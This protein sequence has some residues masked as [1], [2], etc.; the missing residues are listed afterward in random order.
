MTAARKPRPKAK[1]KTPGLTKKQQNKIEQSYG[2]SYALFQAFP[3]LNG[4]LGKAVKQNW[5]PGK[6]QVELRNTDWFKQHSDVWRK[7]TALKYSDPTSYNERLN[8]S[9]AN[10]NNLAASVGVHLSPGA[11]RQLAEQAMLFG[12]DEGQ[13]RDVLSGYVEPSATGDYGGDLATS[14][15]NLNSLA[16]QNGIKLTPQQMQGWMRAIASG[17]GSEEEFGQS[18]RDIAAKT[19]SLYGD[20]I[21]GGANLYDVASPYIQA[22]ASTLEVNPNSL[23][24]FDPT[25]RSALTGQRNDKTGQYEPM[26]VTDFETALRKDKR[27]QY[28]S[29]ARDQARGYVNAL[30]QAWGLA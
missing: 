27:W 15:H 18:I 11:G 14:E 19:F 16:Y 3:E 26:S 25:I 9:L 7:N 22:M 4:L 29:T 21:K 23:D 30:S 5:T 6:F 17:D 10:F 13:V 12:W 20:Q 28:T 2:L 1:S 8:Q 24:L